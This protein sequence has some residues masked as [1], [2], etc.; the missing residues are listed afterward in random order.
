ML[1]A[2]I[3][4]KLDFLKSPLLGINWINFGLGINSEADWWAIKSTVKSLDFLRIP[5][6]TG[7][8]TMQIDH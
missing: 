5:A 4:V 2:L 3:A 1:K 8:Q 7:M 6:D